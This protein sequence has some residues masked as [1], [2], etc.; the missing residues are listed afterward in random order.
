MLSKKQLQKY[1]KMTNRTSWNAGSGMAPR[2][3]RFFESRNYDAM[4]RQGLD[5]LREW[6][7]ALGGGRATRAKF[8]IESRPTERSQIRKKSS[9][10]LSE[11]IF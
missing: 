11:K 7:M 9:I 2:V 4:R 6:F 8:F 5:R 1:K 10:K 3:Q